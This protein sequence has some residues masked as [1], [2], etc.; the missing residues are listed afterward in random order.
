MKK[1]ILTLGIMAIFMVM[2]VTLT[3]CGNK[4]TEKNNE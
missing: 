4:S 1:K 3:G 2:L